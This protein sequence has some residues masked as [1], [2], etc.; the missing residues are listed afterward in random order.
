[1]AFPSG[2]TGYRP[3]WWTP[4]L[5]RLLGWGTAALLAPILL[6]PAGWGI[7]RLLLWLFSRTAAEEEKSNLWAEIRLW[8]GRLARL[9]RK[10]LRKAAR[11]WQKVTG[12]EQSAATF[13]FK[14]SGWG[15]SCGLP[16]RAGETPRE[17]G[18]SLSNCF[19]FG[20]AEIMLI[21]EL[22]CRETYGKKTLARK[23]LLRLQKA[24]HRLR[25][26]LK[27]PLLLRYR[28]LPHQVHQN[29]KD[30]EVIR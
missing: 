24:W 25:S 9:G 20:R 19:P 26:P 14:L 3:S 23:Q 22:F 11:L 21:V 28:L 15:R 12:R 18:V 16:R 30:C 8:F 13:F 7:Y 4:L 1:M 27:W 17:Y 10:L 2:R 5:E 6:V 29:N